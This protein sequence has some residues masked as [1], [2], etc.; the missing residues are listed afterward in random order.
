MRP[1][2]S[3]IIDRSPLSK[4][5]SLDISISYQ[6]W[7]A[8]IYQLVKLMIRYEF[9]MNK[10]SLKLVMRSI[11]K[12]WI[13]IVTSQKEKDKIV[14]LNQLAYYYENVYISYR[15]DNMQV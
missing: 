14:N 15:N 5:K 7:K 10:A 1:L 6:K 13:L 8:W 2:L 4:M 9:P 3:L 11:Y 12:P